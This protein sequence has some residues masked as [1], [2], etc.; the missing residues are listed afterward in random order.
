MR[1]SVVNRLELADGRTR[2]Q[3]AVRLDA[4]DAV[5]G[6]QVLVQGKLE[7]G[8]T[9]FT[10]ND[11]TGPEEEGPDAVHLVTV[12]G[13]HLVLVSL[14]VLSPSQNGSRVVNAGNVDRANFETRLF[15]V[16]NNPSKRTRGIGT[17]E[18]VLVH[19]KTPL[20][21]MELPSGAKTSDLE[22][23]DSII[24][25]KVVDIREEFVVVTN[26]DVLGHLERDDFGI[27]SRLHGNVAV[28]EVQ[29]ACLT[30]VDTVLLE[31]VVS[32]ASLGLCERNT[33]DITSVV[34]GGKGSKGTPTTSNVE[35]AVLLLQI[36]LG[37]DEVELVVLQ[38]LECLG[39]VGVRD[40]AGS[41]N[42]LRAEE[43]GIEVITA[44]V[45]VLDLSLVLLGSMHE[46]IRD[47]VEQNILEQRPGELH[48]APVPSVLEQL[49]QRHLGLNLGSKVGVVESLVRDL[50]VAVVFFAKL[51]VLDIHVEFQ[52]LARER[53]L[54][55]LARTVG[56]HD[57]PVSDSDGAAKQG[58]EKDV[59]EP[60]EPLGVDER[61]ESE[62]NGGGDQD[63]RGKVEVVERAVALG[64]K[65]S[66]GDGG[67]VGQLDLASRSISD[68]SIAVGSGD[69]VGEAVGSAVEFAEFET[70]AVGGGCGDR[71]NT[72]SGRTIGLRLSDRN[73]E[74]GSGR[75]VDDPGVQAGG[76]DIV[77]KVDGLG[78]AVRVEGEVLG[79]TFVSFRGLVRHLEEESAARSQRR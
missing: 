25:K 74:S 31:T 47:Q 15:E 73:S 76:G 51:R 24:V 49:V 56:R 27:V 61:N 41:V 23:K 9:T 32:E 59:A 44:V 40:D 26:P 14:P 10:G 35:D 63:E 66:V 28:I 67:V 62:H 72:R 58:A 2:Q 57:G 38:F 4:V 11:D 21:I 22:N 78:D 19:E 6:V 13:H 50:L 18:H 64:R 68:A 8:A 77:G 3:T 39:L 43:P 60:T 53:N 71:C 5:V 17:G 16:R 20:Q 55:V 65:R 45:V 7:D 79:E 42:H 29:D 33:G 52:R 37:A 54:F 46:H 12:L 48:R 36:E 69:A 70:G 75:R 34:D 30:R 1:S